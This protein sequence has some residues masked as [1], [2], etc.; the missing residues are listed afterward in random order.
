MSVLYI[1]IYSSSTLWRDYSLWRFNIGD[2]VWTQ[3]IEV[4]ERVQGVPTCN[5]HHDART[6]EGITDFCSLFESRAERLQSSRPLSQVS[7]FA[8]GN[9]HPGVLDQS[10]DG[11]ESSAGDKD[12]GNA[13]IEVHCDVPMLVDIPVFD[14]CG[15]DST[16]TPATAVVSPDVLLAAID[17]IPRVEC[18]VP[19]TVSDTSVCPA[20]ISGAGE[21]CAVT[22][23]KLSQLGEPR[24][25]TTISENQAEE[26][27][28]ASYASQDE[29][30]RIPDVTHQIPHRPVG[31][32]NDDHSDSKHN[33]SNK[34]FALTPA[35]ADKFAEMEARF[36]AEK[37]DWLGRK[38]ILDQDLSITIA[39]PDENAPESR[40]SL[41]PERVC[42][43]IQ[44]TRP[45]GSSH[46]AKSCIGVEL[47]EDADAMC[48]REV[49]DDWIQ[50]I[51]KRGNE[52][53]AAL[54]AARRLPLVVTVSKH[55]SPPSRPIEDAEKGLQQLWNV[56]MDENLGIK[57][58]ETPLAGH[59]AVTTSVGRD[60]SK[61][62]LRSPV[63]L[64]VRGLKITRRAGAGDQPASRI[65]PAD[66]MQKDPE[67]Q[68][69]L[70]NHTPD[71]PE[72]TTLVSCS[73]DC[74]PNL[75]DWLEE[76]HGGSGALVQLGGYSSVVGEKEDW[77][78][79]SSVSSSPEST[80]PT[81][82]VCGP[83]PLQDTLQVGRQLHCIELSLTEK[84]PIA[85]TLHESAK[86]ISMSRRSTLDASERQARL[87]YARQLLMSPT[88]PGQLP[89]SN[90]AGRANREKGS[91]GSREGSPAGVAASEPTVRQCPTVASPPGRSP[92]SNSATRAER[93]MGVI[94]S[95]DLSS[96]SGSDA[97]STPRRHAPSVATN[98]ACE[99]R[100]LHT[101]KMLLREEMEAKV[102]T[103]RT[104]GR[105]QGRHLKATKLPRI[106]NGSYSSPDTSMDEMERQSI[107]SSPDLSPPT[108]PTCG[109]FPL[110]VSD[111]EPTVLHCSKLSTPS[112]RRTHRREV[113]IM[114]QSD[115]G[116]GLPC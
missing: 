107:L 40:Q 1:E 8:T 115:F 64:A 55:A 22:L 17:F 47:H 113:R 106:E 50:Q 58:T 46:G 32:S 70:K 45:I 6:W 24:L 26:S 60:F 99:L 103:R 101:A 104:S 25:R 94:F 105:I 41:D 92:P 16:C 27:T 2:A 114:R 76:L 97:E 30:Q 79:S 100:R 82:P 54:K 49:P 84:K 21:D 93:R 33:R 75:E 10:I 5:D 13:H 88:R 18:A 34:L 109:P 57:A 23:E 98:R 42:P 65:P 38:R 77:A 102:D 9:M 83:F 72:N 110:P 61:P 51:V 4:Q 3:P 29:A 91:A 43:S 11:F 95:R 86:V 89:P 111:L 53:R 71:V 63:P 69:F 56:T 48:S 39:P 66:V 108:T 62:V 28:E 68:P 59:N 85:I 12:P 15:Q 116:D 7:E 73:S 19:S 14:T 31:P 87:A 52:E 112:F 81:T 44:K 35:L 74:S 37:A 78:D 80:P 67:A 96:A 20:V 90:S 36:Y